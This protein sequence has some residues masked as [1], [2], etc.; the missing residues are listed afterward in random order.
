MEIRNMAF[1]RR[2]EFI[3]TLFVSLVGVS[4]LPAQTNHAVRSI[5]IQE[6]FERGGVIEILGKVGGKQVELSCTLYFRNE[7]CRKLKTGEYFFRFANASE[8]VYTDCNNV[9][10]YE[11]T[12]QKTLG[13]RQGIFCASDSIESQ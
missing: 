1:S 5:F 10:L 4:S 11:I 12:P 9:I 13:E 3:L 7:Y 2:L 6:S 8:S